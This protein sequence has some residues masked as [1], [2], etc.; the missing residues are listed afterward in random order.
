M[1]KIGQKNLLEKAAHAKVHKFHRDY[2]KVA[3]SLFNL[4]E[5]FSRFEISGGAEIY[6]CMRTPAFKTSYNTDS[7]DPL[8]L[9]S[10][11]RNRLFK[12]I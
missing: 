10:C 4:A 2:M 1:F 6:S 12:R 8:E 3:F 5:I 9:S 11:N 7:F